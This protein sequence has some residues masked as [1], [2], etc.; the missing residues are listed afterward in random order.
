MMIIG[1]IIG[2]SFLITTILLAA[3]T[4]TNFLKD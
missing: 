3:D 4:I 2:T 1:L